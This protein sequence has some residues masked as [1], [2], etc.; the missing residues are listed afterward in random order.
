MVKTKYNM[1]EIFRY[2]NKLNKNFYLKDSEN[3]NKPWFYEPL[4]YKGNKPFSL[5]YETEE[6]C[7]LDASIDECLT[8]LKKNNEKLKIINDFFDDIEKSDKKHLLA[9]TTNRDI[10]TIDRLYASSAYIIK[11][12]EQNNGE[13]KEWLNELKILESKS[14]K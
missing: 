13:I 2:D 8:I 6:L 4:N 14:N 12:L 7:F 5:G 3:G 9:T 10:E 11:K 1:F